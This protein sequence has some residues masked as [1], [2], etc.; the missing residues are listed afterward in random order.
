M[1]VVGVDVKL[2]GIFELFVSEFKNVVGTVEVFD[3][4][5]KKFPWLLDGIVEIFAA[6]F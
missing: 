1:L 5:F 3:A 6:E 2:E 4:T